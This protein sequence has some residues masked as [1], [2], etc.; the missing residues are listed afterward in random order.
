[1]DQLE[2]NGIGKP[3]VLGNRQKPMPLDELLAISSL[4]DVVFEGYPFCDPKSSEIRKI[5]VLVVLDPFGNFEIPVSTE[6]VS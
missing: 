2:E 1:M 4:T 3:A 6:I 5:Q